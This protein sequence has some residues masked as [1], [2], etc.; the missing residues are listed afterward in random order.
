MSHQ[1]L[2]EGDALNITLMLAHVRCLS[3]LIHTLPEH[4]YQFKSYFKKLFTTVKDYEEALNK[5]T[6][7]QEGTKD[8]KEQQEIYDLL[9]DLTYDVRDQ[10]IKNRQHGNNNSGTNS[11]ETA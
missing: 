11:G 1:N 7:Y 6:D 9:M 2:K 5:L 4:R 3:E 10:V 8:S